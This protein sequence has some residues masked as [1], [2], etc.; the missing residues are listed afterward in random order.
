MLRPVDNDM[1]T[2]QNPSQAG[3]GGRVLD[4]VELVRPD[5]AVLRLGPEEPVPTLP[6]RVALPGGA[7]G[8][9]GAVQVREVVPAEGGEP[10]VALVLDVPTGGESIQTFAST[11]GGTAETQGW[12]CNLFP[13]LC[14]S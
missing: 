12:F 6:L 14:A 2:S 7:A 4:G 10:V 13:R 11:S 5:V 3:Q 9:S 1:P 8:S